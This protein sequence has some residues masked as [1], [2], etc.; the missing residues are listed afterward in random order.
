MCGETTAK[1]RRWRARIN[2]PEKR[3]RSDRV[4]TLGPPGLMRL[5]VSGALRL[6]LVL[7]AVMSCCLNGDVVGSFAQVCGLE[8]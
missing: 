1:P 2:G 6:F 5:K 3:E 4:T 7:L 8:I